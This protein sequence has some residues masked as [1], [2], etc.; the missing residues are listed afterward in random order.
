VLRACA[1]VC[2]ACECVCYVCVR[3]YDCVYVRARMS[4]R[5]VELGS[6]GEEGREASVVVHI[7]TLYCGLQSS[8]P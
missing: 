7:L 4:Y 3:L 6:Q 5:R 8:A 1:S 2:F